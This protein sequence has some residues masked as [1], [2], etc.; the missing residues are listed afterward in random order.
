MSGSEVITV[1]SLISSVITIIETSQDVFAAASSADGLHEAFRTVSQNVPLVLNILRD[2]K[3]AQEQVKKDYKQTCDE[4]LKRDIEQSSKD[5]EP[6]IQACQDDAKQLQQIFQKVVPE[7]GSSWVERYKKAAHAVL[8][9]KKRKVEDLMKEILEKLQLLHTSR[10]FKSEN[11]KKNENRSMELKT[12]I[13]QLSELSSSLLENEGQY[14]HYG[15]GGIFIH[16]GKGTQ[17]NYSQSG[18]SGN[19]QYIGGTQN[20]G[21]D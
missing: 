16:P 11:E 6:L 9:G 21:R 18:G 1:L 17:Q 4:D 5:V 8:P 20:F 7:D 3:R 14:N 12:A 13:N 10:F 19:R 15:S 2:C